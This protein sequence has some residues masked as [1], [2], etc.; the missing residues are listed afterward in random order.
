[1]DESRSV[2][3]D[4]Q[5]SRMEPFCLGASRTLGG[6]GAIFGF[7]W[8][9]CSGLRGPERRGVIFLRGSGRGSRSTAGSEIGGGRGFSTGHSMRYPMTQPWNWH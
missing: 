8:K 4:L 9:K 5:W 1:M 3:A 7:F 6:R 2:I